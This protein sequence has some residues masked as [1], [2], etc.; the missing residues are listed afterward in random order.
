MRLL[1]F[2]AALMLLGTVAFSQDIR[3]VSWGM[4]MDQVK[5]VESNKPAKQD[6]ASIYYADKA[7]GFDC[8]I[9]YLFSSKGLVGAAYMFIIDH[10]NKNDF[11]IDYEEVRDL[12]AGKYGDAK[13]DKQ[14][15]KNDLYKDS[16]QDWGMAI[17][18]GHLE[19]QTVFENARTRIMLNLYGD[20]F[21]MHLA[22]YYY[23]IGSWETYSEESEVTE[24][25]GL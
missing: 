18:V 13:S 1:A 3:K 15:W 8:I 24:S 16:Q 5:A 23:S 7:A 19:C 21:K 12:L 10:T 11:I 6:K 25:E 20:N 22:S 2:G 9:Q 17:S 14:I 4:T